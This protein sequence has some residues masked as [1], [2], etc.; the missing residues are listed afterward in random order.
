MMMMMQMMQANANM[1]A[2]Q[3]NKKSGDEQEK[4]DKAETKKSEEI[5]KL[6]IPEF[7]APSQSTEEKIDLSDLTYKPSNE[8]WPLPPIPEVSNAEAQKILS[9]VKPIAAP[10]EASPSPAA[11]VPPPID[12]GPSKIGKT[13]DPPA[14]EPAKIEMANQTSPVPGGSGSL[15]V[16]APNKA[17]EAGP[18]NSPQDE[19]VSFGG[20]GVTKEGVDYGGADGSGGSPNREPSGGFGA[21]IADLMGFSVPGHTEE[22]EELQAMEKEGDAGSNIFEYASYRYRKLG[23]RGNAGRFF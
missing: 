23:I 2:A 13:I 14:T 15:L 10:A 20:R 21:M 3:Q 22:Q 7:K 19:L 5:A 17:G 9:Q 4:K 11:A 16:A 8:P 1:Q 6:E 12:P 18:T